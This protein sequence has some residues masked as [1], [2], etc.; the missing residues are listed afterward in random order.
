LNILI[1][2]T[3]IILQL[4]IEGGGEVTLLSKTIDGIA[5]E[6]GARYRP[7]PNGDGDHSDDDITPGNLITESPNIVFDRG[8]VYGT[9]WQ[10]ANFNIAAYRGKKITLIL[11]AGDV[12]D[13]IFDTAILL[14]E[15]K[16]Q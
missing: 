1:H 8:G 14:D 13:S 2:N 15:C 9:G 12:G 16:L 4:K 6:F 7:D 11:S 3:R 10:S 5:G